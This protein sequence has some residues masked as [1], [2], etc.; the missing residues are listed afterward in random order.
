MEVSQE[1]VLRAYIYIDDKCILSM[2]CIDIH[3][4]HMEHINCHKHV[5]GPRYDDMQQGETSRFLQ[6]QNACLIFIL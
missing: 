2:W 1:Y 3:Y 5:S 4:L 6:H